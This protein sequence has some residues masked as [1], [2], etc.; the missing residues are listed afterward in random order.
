[1]QKEDLTFKFVDSP[2]LLQLQ[3]SDGNVISIDHEGLIA[4]STTKTVM[5]D[6]KETLVLG[7]SI[8]CKDEDV[9]VF[10]SGTTDY[11]LFGLGND[12]VLQN[13]M[14]VRNYYVPNIYLDKFKNFI[15]NDTLKKEWPDD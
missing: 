3:F 8:Q 1:M 9:T 10:I 6:S 4:Y 11:N 5:F 15:K 14:K 2:N 13:G 7:N 12:I